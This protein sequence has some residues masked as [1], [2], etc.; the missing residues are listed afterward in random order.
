MEDNKN[1]IDGNCWLAYFDILGFK[2]EVEWAE[3][4]KN[5]NFILSMCECISGEINL[6]R[7]FEGFAKGLVNIIWF[8]DTFVFYSSNDSEECLSAIEC[9]AHQF[10]RTMFTARWH[11]EEK[12]HLENKWPSG[13]TYVPLRGCLSYGHFYAD[14]DKNIYWGSV[15]NEAYK[16]AESQDWIGYVLSEK[17]KDQMMKCHASYWETI[18]SCYKKYDVP[19]KDRKHGS[20]NRLYAYYADEKIPIYDGS[21]ICNIDHSLDLANGLIWMWNSIKGYDNLCDEQKQKI[22]KK[23]ENTKEFLLE[24]YPN[25]R[26]L[27]KDIGK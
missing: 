27:L 22:I 7:Q 4:K 8:S 15:L 1:I 24:V 10:F 3:D 14:R 26:S 2:R 5:N 20:P 17:A 21:G 19:M 9:I 16:L 13:N 18:K 23:Y 11:F 6:K 12:W 25:S